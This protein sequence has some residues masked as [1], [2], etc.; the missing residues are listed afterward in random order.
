MKGP[1]LYT[2]RVD[3]LND[4]TAEQVLAAM[5]SVLADVR[6]KG[7]TAGEL[8]QAKTRMRSSFLDDMEGG[9]MPGFGRA[10]LLAAF[11]LFNDDPGA[12]TPSSAR[13]TR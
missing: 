1:M 5:E 8:A 2:M 11:A 12:S 10:N 9:M 13:S 7:I 6:D 3:Y 4:K